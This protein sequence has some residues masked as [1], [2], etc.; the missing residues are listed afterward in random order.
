MASPTSAPAAARRD[1][2]AVAGP[3]E[4]A[5]RTESPPPRHPRAYGVGQLVLT[6]S[7][8]TDPLSWAG[9]SDQLVIPDPY[10][11]TGGNRR[12]E[13]CDNRRIFA[14]VVCLVQMFDA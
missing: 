3:P 12:A 6:G 2:A 13:D 8:I 1:A 9:I 4:G 11:R 14:V 5:H 7:P 10:P